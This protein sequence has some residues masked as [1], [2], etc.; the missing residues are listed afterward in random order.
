MKHRQS[1]RRQALA[2][3]GASAFILAPFL[4]YVWSHVQIVTIGY[5]IEATE[6]RL[7]A[8]EQENHA[9]RLSRA[10]LE[11]LPAI[12][13]RALALGLVPLPPTRLMVVTLPGSAVSRSPA[14]RRAGD[15][16]R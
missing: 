10:R 6:A 5:Q 7:H 14:A 16:S 9:L 1:R 13:A 12:E 11:S 3:V 4:A 8:L 15:R 2:V